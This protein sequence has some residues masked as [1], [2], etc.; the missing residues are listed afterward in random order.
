MCEECR[1]PPHGR[2][3]SL[4][5]IAPAVLAILLTLSLGGCATQRDSLQ[6][7]A[8]YR[9]NHWQQDFLQIAEY[10]AENH[11]SFTDSPL[12]I[13]AKG[14]Y[15]S[16]VE[17][18]MRALEKS[19]D[20]MDWYLDV[21]WFLEKLEDGHSR[22]RVKP[23]ERI[24]PIKVQWFGNELRVTAVF[25]ETLDDLLHARITRIGHLSVPEF[26][27]R[28]NE[29]VPS[30]PGNYGFKR[31]FSPLLAVSRAMLERLG[32]IDAEG[33]VEIGY[34]PAEDKAGT[35]QASGETAISAQVEGY[36][37][38]AS[39]RVPTFARNSFTAPGRGNWFQVVEAEAGASESMRESRASGRPD[40]RVAGPVRPPRRADAV[41]LQLNTLEGA[42]DSGFIESVFLA[43]AGTR[44]KSLIIDLRDNW[45]GDPRWCD[46]IL[47]YLV[48]APTDLYIYEGW[49]RVDESRNMKVADGVKR[50][51]PAGRGLRPT[52]GLWVLTGPATFSS[53]TFIAV[54][55]KDNGL[56]TLVGEPCGNSSMRFGNLARETTLANLGYSFATTN[57]IWRRAAPSLK[58][59]RPLL[60]EPD[61]LVPLEFADWLARRDAPF[62]YVMGEISDAAGAFPAIGNRKVPR[63]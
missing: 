7:G 39:A 18:T 33:R 49:E 63:P 56:G 11:A 43:V 32:L 24:L 20:A 21:S 44:S 60:I 34:L 27:D 12:P 52:G 1:F 2:R 36:A 3:L 57:R 31:I 25:D 53:A 58:V 28:L 50:A 54:A 15:G 40:D 23:F 5:G 14:E 59:G 8:S 16:L 46:E 9:Y 51:L 6:G 45:G 62:E 4:S 37:S 19:D 13:L 17:E 47:R 38:A 22:L 10:M 42:P 29:Y 26:E 30:D 55:V 48:D 41:Y 35:G 61:V